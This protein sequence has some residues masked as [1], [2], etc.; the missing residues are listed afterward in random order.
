MISNP[1]K[2]KTLKI[3]ALSDAAMVSLPIV[4]QRHSTNVL[5]ELGW[6][7]S[8]AFCI[9]NYV[10]PRPHTE[11]S[12]VTNDG[13]RSH[14]SDERVKASPSSARLCPSG[15]GDLTAHAVRARTPIPKTW[16][17]SYALTTSHPLPN[18]G[19]RIAALSVQLHQLSCPR[20]NV[21]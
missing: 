4:D 20:A 8:C 3:D 10:Q 5:G 13:G 12:A 6:E 16:L 14:V 2:T 1:G 17:D 11:L 21:S 18:Q 15:I 19:R 9:E 7:P